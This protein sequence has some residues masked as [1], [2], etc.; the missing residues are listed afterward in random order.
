MNWLMAVPTAA[1]P[2]ATFAVSSKP[3]HAIN[4]NLYSIFFETEINFGG[5]GGLYAELLHNRDFEALG[6]GKLLNGEDDGALGPPAVGLDP[7]EPPG[8][9]TDFRPWSPVGDV[10]V[11]IDN[12]TAPFSTNP[13][14]LRLHG[15]PSSGVTNPGYWG[16]GVR[17]GVGY[18]LSLYA[19][20]AGVALGLRALLRCSVG[21]AIAT[22]ASLQVPSAERGAE[23]ALMAPGWHLLNATLPPPAELCSSSGGSATFELQLA[24]P[25]RLDQPGE[26]TRGGTAQDRGQGHVHVHED[27][28]RRER[29]T[30]EVYLDSVSLR[31]TDA[32]DGLFRRDVFERLRAMNP[33]FVRTPGGNYLEGHGPR[34][35]WQWKATVGPAAAR[36]GHYNSAWGYWVTDGLGVYELLRLSEL[37]NCESQVSPRAPAA[38]HACPCACR[39]LHTAGRAAGRCGTWCACTRLNTR[40]ENVHLHACAALRLYGLLDGCPVHTSQRVYRLCHRRGRPPQ[41]CQRS[42]LVA[43]GGDAR[44]HGPSQAVWP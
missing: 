6:R 31:H 36:R 3:R 20:S 38:L 17:P 22:E 4:P 11:A 29:A 5:E 35:R 26:R 18:H 27:R 32:V 12:R 24:A 15:E 34:T 2:T 41:L 25:E 1:P 28:G 33:G 44:G 19:R 13:N 16:I 8:I 39:A 14:T 40:L 7:H 43:L 42:P 10:V 21:G 23:G 30:Y 9:P 37:L